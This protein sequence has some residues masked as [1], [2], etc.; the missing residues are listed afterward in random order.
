MKYYLILIF[1]LT[2]FVLE[3]NAQQKDETRN[4]VSVQ[5]GFSMYET[6]DYSV[7]Y[8]YL[9]CEYVGLGANIGAWAVDS[10]SGILGESNDDKWE[11]QNAFV[12]PSL[13]LI[14]PNLFS[15]KQCRFHIECEP[16]IVFSTRRRIRTLQSDMET[17]KEYK[18]DC[19]SWSCDFGF[20]VEYKTVNFLVYYSISN[21]DV[22]RK[23]DSKN[24]KKYSKN[25]VDGIG[26]KIA[27]T[28]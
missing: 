25:M 3:C 18:T 7:G 27:I 4:I 17:Y 28:F 21:L 1:L 24:Q 9:F 6:S 19:I 15:V 12:K 22:N 14:S 13:L 16:G 20:A 2:S 11:R 8:H 23:Y 5:A 26:L 10:S